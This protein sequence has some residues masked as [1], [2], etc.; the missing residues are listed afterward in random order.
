[1]LL[2]VAAPISSYWPEFAA[3][4]KA[5]AP[6]RWALG[7][8]VGVP[9][10]DATLTLDEV[11]AWDPVVAAVAGQNPEWPPGTDHGYHARTFGWMVGELVRR[12]SGVSLGRFL[13]AELAGPLGLDFW[14]GLPPEVEPR[15]ATLY[16]SEQPPFE[17]GS[18]LWRVLTGPS[19]LFA[20]N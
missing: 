19:D 17:P 18:L 11:L 5:E 14:V 1:G 15:V 9:A 10:V 7:H 4:G 16:S 20:D 2:D 3:N 8:R 12:I 6:V 13:A